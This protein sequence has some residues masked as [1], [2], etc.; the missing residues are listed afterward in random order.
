MGGC[1]CCA[2]RA[3]ADRAPVHIYVCRPCFMLC[4]FTVFSDLW[5]TVNFRMTCS[6]FG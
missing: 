1:C 2:S 3:E 5:A 4:E 6:T